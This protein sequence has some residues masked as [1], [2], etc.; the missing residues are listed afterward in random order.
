MNKNIII[1]FFK[2][3]TDIEFEN[4]MNTNDSVE[5]NQSIDSITLLGAIEK[6]SVDVVNSVYKKNKKMTHITIEMYVYLCNYAK[7]RDRLSL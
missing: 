3:N 7:K 5:C 4:K 1:L 6:I 2:R